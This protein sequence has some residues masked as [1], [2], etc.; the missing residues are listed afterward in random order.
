MKK[1]YKKSHFVTQMQSIA[2]HCVSLRQGL[3]ADTL[4]A[5]FLIKSISYDDKLVENAFLP[6]Y[7]KTLGRRNLPAPAARPDTTRRPC[8]C[9]KF[10]A[11]L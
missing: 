1:A 10:V 3:L 6:T 8:T 5:N 2:T 4:S 11:A 9:N 7:R